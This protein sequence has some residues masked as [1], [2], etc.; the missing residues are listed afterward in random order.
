VIPVVSVAQTQTI[1]IAAT[2]YPLPKA[3]DGINVWINSVPAPIFA[4]AFEN[5]YQQIN[6]QVPWEVQG[7]P[8]NVAV[9]QNG[10]EAQVQVAYTG[11]TFTSPSSVFFADVNGFGIVQH[12][13]DYS[14]VT[15]QNPAHAGEYQVNFQA[16]ASLPA[17]NVPIGFARVLWETY[18]TSCPGPGLFAILLTQE[19]RTVLLPVQ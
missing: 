3:L 9:F 11:T 4:I 12:V 2:E 16:P 13:S 15:P 17:G 7:E 5:G 19:S 18:Y 14:L 6:V 1:S 10:I 8:S